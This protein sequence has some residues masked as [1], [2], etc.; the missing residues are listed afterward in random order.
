MN[1]VVGKSSV[2]ALLAGDA[3][4]VALVATPAS[5]DGAIVDES[6][7][8]V[9]GG[10]AL[11][12]SLGVSLALAAEGKLASGAAEGVVSG[13]V[14]VATEGASAELWV[15][16]DDGAGTVGE[17]EELPGAVLAGG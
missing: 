16:E 15:G 12:V 5:V 4:V 13:G 11:G 7:G 17:A 8:A 10:P 14:W 6:V 9:R 1:T 2:S 3:E